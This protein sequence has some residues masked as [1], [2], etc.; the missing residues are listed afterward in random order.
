MREENVWNTTKSHR[1]FAPTFVGHHLFP[2]KNFNE[3][4]LMNSISIPKKVINL[5]ILYTLNP[6]LINLNIDFIPGN[7][8]FGS[9]KLTKNV[10]LDKYKYS[11]YSIGFDSCSEFSFADGSFGNRVIIF[12]ADM[13]SSLHIDDKEK[14]ILIL[15]KEHK[16]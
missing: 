2:D 8:L 5:N 4:G 11:G 12:G 6:Q 7:C 14:G 9:V 1:N 3:H 10:D 16:D 15:G 13:S